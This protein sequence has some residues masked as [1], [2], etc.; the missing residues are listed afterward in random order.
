[1]VLL[2]PCE[3]RDYKTA[4]AALA[5]FNSNVEFV[6]SDDGNPFEFVTKD[7]LLDNVEFVVLLFDNN[8]NFVTVRLNKWFRF[9]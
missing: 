5:G 8:N 3:G 6:V 9:W 1:M 7:Q 2:K 4:D